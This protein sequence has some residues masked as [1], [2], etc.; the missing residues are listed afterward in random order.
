MLHFFLFFFQ[1]GNS[2]EGCIRSRKRTRNP[3]NDKEMKQKRLVQHG[4][5][6]V[7]KSGS[8]I[9][10]KEFHVQER[11]KCKRNCAETID[12]TRQKE[13]FQQ[14]YQF[15]NWS[16]KQIFLWSLLKSSITKSKLIPII[17]LRRK[18]CTYSYYLSDVHGKT[19]QVCLHFLTN[20]L[21][22][23]KSTV[24]RA[25]DRMI[26][27]PNA[28]EKRGQFRNK[29]KIVADISYLKS[30]MKK[31][32][33]HQSHYGPSKSNSIVKYL[34]PNLNIIKMYREY[35][36]LSKVMKRKVLSE[37][38]FRNIFNTQFNLNFARLKVDTCKTCDTLTTKLKCFDANE[39]E[40]WKNEK[41][42]HLRLVGEMG[43]L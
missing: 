39:H 31:F 34:N 12:V 36:L 2:S 24:K 42:N 43:L 13:I 41:E 16:K 28:V 11:C 17:P 7:S 30:F 32:P 20:C 26:S 14:F 18:M 25:A 40:K 33:C 22:I 9:K 5:E 1:D 35:C 8:I 3:Q 38:M 6:H 29:F 10:R 23:N 4:D 21:Q 19:H 27:N 15:E 37:W